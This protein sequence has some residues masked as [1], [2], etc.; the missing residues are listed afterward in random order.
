MPRTERRGQRVTGADQV[1]SE[2]R[3]LLVRGRDDLDTGRRRNGVER[4]L[5][6][7]R[8]TE[9]GQAQIGAADDRRHGSVDGR[10][11]AGARGE[12][13]KQDGHAERDAHGGQ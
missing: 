13:G 8:L 1:E 10:M 3:A 4:V 7:A 12:A 2:I 5:R 9:R 11:D 6:E